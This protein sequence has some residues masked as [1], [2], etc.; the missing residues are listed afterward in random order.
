[1]KKETE[2]SAPFELSKVKDGAW[3]ANSVDIP[4]LCLWSFLT[5]RD[6][7]SNNLFA[8]GEKV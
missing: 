8:R 2:V 5:N 4:Y 1:M 3:K 7:P 6:M